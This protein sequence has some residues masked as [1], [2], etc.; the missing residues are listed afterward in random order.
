MV[1]KIFLV[2][3]TI[4]VLTTCIWAQTEIE[5]NIPPDTLNIEQAVIDSLE[6]RIDPKLL[7]V[8]MN[9]FLDEKRKMEDNFFLP[10]LI[11]KENFHLSSPFNLNMRIKKNGFSEIPFAT[12]NLQTVQNNR[13]IYKTIYKRGNILYNSWEYSLP[14]ALTETYMGL[15]D[16]DMNNIAVSLMKGGIF[17]IPDFDMQLDY[18]G[19]KG[20]WQG[21]ENEASK[22][23]HLHLIYDLGFARIHFDNSLINQTLPSG[24]DIYAY[25]GYMYPNYSASNK[26]NEYS[27]TVENNIIDFGF[28]Y[29]SSDYKMDE[30]WRKK[31]NLMQFLV[32]KK[33]YSRNHN[34]NLSYEFVSENVTSYNYIPT[35]PTDI[36]KKDNSYH[37]LSVDHDSNIVGF[38]IGNTGFYRDENNFQLDSSLQKELFH[39]FSLCGEFNTSSTEF[40]PNHL[41]SCLLNQLRSSVDGGIF[42]DFPLIKTKVV[43]GQHHIEDFD[44]KYYSLQNTFTLNLFE[45]VYIKYDLW[46][47]KEQ[48]NYQI[49]N[50]SE[51]SSFP[52]WQ[53]FD[54][55]E[56]TYNLKH[57]NAI[58][59]GLKHIYH[60][61]Y[62]YYY[63]ACESPTTSDTQNIDAYLKIQLTDRFEISVDAINLTNNKMMFTNYDHPETHFN[64][65]VHWIF[66][67]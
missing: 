4:I 10:H 29:L 48:T 17:G 41:S 55:L 31:R 51:I 19:E 43:M 57:N 54:A 7:L 37:I 26:E 15:G 27:F 14:V 18:L 67:N 35:Q 33:L 64:F 45:D 28:K 2:I 59:L 44:G 38:K 22:N 1:M 66:A 11:Y 34:L 5:E 20:I 21:Y 12:G 46:L 53:M 61:D 52:E 60:S 36:S 62:S 56:V 47:R 49:D 50:N 9:N 3:L 23:F 25:L 42:I 8:E 6:E 32:Q 58:I 30:W 63:D 13:S 65:N 39:G 16:I 40:Y 24:K